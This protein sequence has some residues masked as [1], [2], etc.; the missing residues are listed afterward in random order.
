MLRLAFLGLHLMLKDILKA[1]FIY[2]QP[3]IVRSDT[4]TYIEGY[5]TGI[6]PDRF[7]VDGMIFLFVSVKAINNEIG[8]SCSI[9][10]KGI[11]E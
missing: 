4:R 8:E 6:D 3:V 7:W 5:I 9:I 1:V 10:V 11:D 2:Q